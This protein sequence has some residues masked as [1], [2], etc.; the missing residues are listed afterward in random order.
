[1]SFTTLIDVLWRDIIR[2]VMNFYL[3]IWCVAYLLKLGLLKLLELCPSL[4]L[5]TFL[6]CHI[7]LNLTIGGWTLLLHLYLL[8]TE[9]V[10]LINIFFKDCFD[11][12]YSKLSLIFNCQSNC[13]LNDGI[14]IFEFHGSHTKLWCLVL[15]HYRSYRMNATSS[16]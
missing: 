12:F 6:I 2:I 7:V 5:N 8:I 1:M 9:E 11:K 10:R 4:N 16:H 14:I 13:W 3:L 15:S